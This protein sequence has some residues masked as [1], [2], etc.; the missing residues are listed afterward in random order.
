MYPSYHTRKDCPALP[1]QDEVKRV[2]LAWVP[3]GGQ[4]CGHCAHAIGK[5]PGALER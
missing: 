3:R 2:P 4:M 5:S 1:G